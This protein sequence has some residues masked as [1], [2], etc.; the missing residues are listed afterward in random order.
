MYF[1]IYPFNYLRLRNEAGSLVLWR[2]L[3]PVILIVVATVMFFEAIPSSN[4][5]GKD[6]FVEKMGGIT[7]SLTGF[8]I[9]GLLA[10][11]T[12]TV[13]QSALDQP[14][15]I[16][17]VFLGKG[18]A[19]QSLSRREYVCL[20]FAY[21]SALSLAY[22]L[23]SAFSGAGAEAIAKELTGSS[24]TVRGITLNARWI[25]GLL[26]EVGVGILVS[27]VAL[28]TGYGLYYL[29]KKIYEREPVIERG[30]A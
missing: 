28:T 14:I 13:N 27:H 15:K 25:V 30:R 3:I 23:F 29:T 21:L 24:A 10:V 11:A 12:F 2:D 16:G 6:G 20:M 22:S 7:S 1:V 17:P 26:G 5:Y 18:D 4:F 9:A 8:Y 19:R